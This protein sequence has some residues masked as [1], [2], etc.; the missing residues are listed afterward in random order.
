MFIPEQ[1]WWNLVNIKAWSFSRLSLYESCPYRAK[2]QYIDKIPEPERPLPPGKSE[3]ANER[4]SR[5]HEQAEHYI[6]NRVT[7]LAEELLHF[8]IELDHVREIQAEDESRVSAEGM[9]CFNDAW[10]SVAPD[11]YDNVW[12]RVIIDALVWLSPTEVVVIDFKTGKRYGNEIKHGQ[13]MTLYALAVA[14]KY[15]EVE[16][17]HT[18]L[19]YLDL[20]DLAYQRY[21]KDQALCFLKNFNMRALTLNEDTEFKPKPNKSSCMFCPYGGTDNKWVTKTGDCQF[22]VG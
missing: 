14:M 1:Q 11:D 20:N 4:G 10:D 9:W 16:T 12:L 3:H 15:P 7:D 19:W 22:G 13:Q 5:I 17:I 2:L 6:T 21:T 8:R 18:E